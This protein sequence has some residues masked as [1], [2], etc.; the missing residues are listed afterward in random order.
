MIAGDVDALMVPYKARLGPD[1]GIGRPCHENV[2]EHCD[3]HRSM[4]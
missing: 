4:P 2:A 1:G 3:A